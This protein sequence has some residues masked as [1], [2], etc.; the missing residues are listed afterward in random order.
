MPGRGE[1]M[2]WGGGK[3]LGKDAIANANANADA[4]ADGN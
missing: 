2:I 4:D 1:T 3:E